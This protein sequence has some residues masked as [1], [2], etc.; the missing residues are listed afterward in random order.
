MGR[1]QV[2]NTQVLINPGNPSTPSSMSF[3]PDNILTDALPHGAIVGPTEN[4]YI[5]YYVYQAMGGELSLT[6]LNS[7]MQ[8]AQ[9]NITDGATSFLIASDQT[10]NFPP[11]FIMVVNGNEVY[12]IGAVTYN[13][14][15]ES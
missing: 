3:L 10:E 5:D 1:P 14:V 2:T 4:V 11:G 13:P 9:V 8:V 12:Q 6:V 7:P 15:A